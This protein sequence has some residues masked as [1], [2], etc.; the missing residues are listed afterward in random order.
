MYKHLS[1]HVYR[2]VNPLVKWIWLCGSNK[3]LLNLWDLSLSVSLSL[4]LS[5]TLSLPHNITLHSQLVPVLYTLDAVLMCWLAGAMCAHM[6]NTCISI[7]ADTQRYEHTKD[8]LLNIQHTHT[9]WE[10]NMYTLA[11]QWSTDDWFYSHSHGTSGR[12]IYGCG[13]LVMYNCSARGKPTVACVY[14]YVCVHAAAAAAAC[15]GLIVCTH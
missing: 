10:F 1:Y 2:P 4:S 5:L 3:Q 15:A 13:L 6:W 7:S 8:A 12:A 9:L 11:E 14:N